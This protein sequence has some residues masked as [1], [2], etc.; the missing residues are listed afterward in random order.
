MANPKAGGIIP[1]ERIERRIYVIRGVKV[2][3]SPDLAQLYGVAAKRLN[4]AVRRN[5]ERFP[6]DFMFQ[7][8]PEEDDNLKS[9][10]A[11]SSWG[12]ARR[13]RP[14]AFSE[15]GVA[16]LSAV[17]HSPTAIAVSIA[18][19]WISDRSRLTE[20]VFPQATT[21]PRAALSEE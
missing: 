17:L 19:H 8:N 21:L 10:I 16:M 9:Q 2:M 18:T 13:A 7:L 15:Q 14:Y 6:A 12:R 4:E 11:T 3:L 20:R 5:I 1:I